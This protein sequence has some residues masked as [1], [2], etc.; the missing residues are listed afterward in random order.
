MKGEGTDTNGVRRLAITADDDEFFRAGLK[1]MLTRR[2]GFSEVLETSSFDA[3]I[4][5]LEAR[6]GAA[7]ALFDLQMPG[8]DSPGSLRTIREFFP[9]TRVAMVSASRTRED[10]LMALDAGA[11]GYISKGL[12]MNEMAHVLEMVM[13]GWVYVPPSIADIPSDPGAQLLL[14]GREER[15]SGDVS[16]LSPRQRQVLGL[17]VRGKSN[18]E[19]G[20][21]LNL[22]DGTVKVHMAALFKNLGVNSRAAAAALGARHLN[23]EEGRDGR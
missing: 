17:L 21:I 5:Q 10:I 9:D 4:E 19:I 11:H 18:K 16:I 6:R 20:R 22:S 14:R 12:S 23:G 2:L 3:A 8:M 15:Q 7:L 1:A 13:D